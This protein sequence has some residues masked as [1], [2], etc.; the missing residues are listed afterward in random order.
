MLLA[1]DI[2]GTKTELAVYASVTTLTTPVA[3]DIFP[4]NHYKG[5]EEIIRA[6]LAKNNVQIDRACFGVAGPV[7]AAKATITNLPWII[8]AAQLKD[9]L[10]LKSVVL[11][12]DLEAIAS[13][14]PFLQHAELETLNSGQS[15]VNGPLAVI[16]P[17]TGLGEAFLTWD[18]Q[19]YLAHTS[20][21]GHADF[22]P[23]D[24][25]QIGLLR[26]LQPRLD[27]VSYEWVCSGRGMPNIY[28]YLKESNYAPEPAWLA[29]QLAQAKDPNSI[30]AQA[31]LDKADPLCVATIKTFVSILG[32]EAGNLA[33]KILSTGGIYIGGGIPRHVLPFLQEEL[34]MKAFLR[35]G[36]LAEVLKPMP[37]HVIL[38]AKVG[39]QGAAYRGFALER[40]AI[41]NVM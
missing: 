6:F 41:P 7:V 19:S 10:K 3:H 39:L 15:A 28:A 22:A 37:V 30:I 16:A 5:L 29:E 38:N 13:A 32:A 21:G 31:A 4:S 12:N 14:V 25:L 18:S 2:G 36:R 8:D 11:M 27:H 35:K 33:L 1:G 24:E 40:D 17:G 26:Y 20:E 9:T 34:F 23:T